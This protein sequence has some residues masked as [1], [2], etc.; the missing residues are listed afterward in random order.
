MKLRKILFMLVLVL[1]LSIGLV[2]CGNKDKDDDNNQNQQQPE[3]FEPVAIETIATTYTNNQAVQAEGIVYGVTA[4]GFY[5]SDSAD[6][7]LF[8][9]IGDAFKKD[10]AVG[11]KVQVTGKFSYAKN[12]IQINAVSKYEKAGTGTA[13]VAKAESTIPAVNAL[14]NSDKRVFGKVVTLTGTLSLDATNMY[15]LTDL[16]GNRIFFDNNSD[17][18]VLAQ[19][20]NKRVTLNAVVYKYLSSDAVWTLSYVGGSSEIVESPLTFDVVKEKALEH[21]NAVVAKNVYGALELPSVHSVLANIT[22]SWAVE[23]NDYLTIVDNVATVVIDSVDHELVL[24]VTVS[25]GNQSETIDFAITLKGIVEQTVSEFYANKPMVD[26]SKVIVRGII[27][28]FARNQSLSTRSV[29]VKDP[30]TNETLPIDFAKTGDYILNESETFKSLQIGD[31]IVVTA[32][33]SFSGR[34]TVQCVSK[35]EKRSSGNAVSHDFEN[36]YVLDSKESYENLAANVYDYSGQLVKFANP[37]INYSTSGVP[38]DTNWVQLGYNEKIGAEGF[39]INGTARKFALLIAAVNENLGTDSWHKNYEVPFVNGPA[40]QFNLEI[41]AYCLYVSDSYVAFIVPDQSAFTVAP[42]DQIVMDLGDG[43]PTSVEMGNITLITE[44]KYATGAI[45]WT[46]SHPAVID[47]ATGVVSEV[48]ENTV[49]TLTATYVFEGETKEFVKEVTVLAS[50]SISVSEL[51]ASAED[52]YKYKVEGVVV[53]FT[54]DGNTH[55]YRKGVLLM[56]PETGDLVLVDGLGTLYGVVY[57]DYVDASGKEITIGTMITVTGNYGVDSPEIGSGP[58]QTGRIHLDVSTGGKVEAGEVVEFAFNDEK[59]IVID[60]DEAQGAAVSETVPFGKLIKFVGTVENPIYFGGSSNTAPINY[61]VFMNN[62][63]DNNGTKY[64]GK[65]FSFKADNNEANAGAAWYSK[66]LA[67]PEA[68]VCPN[69]TNAPRAVVGTVYG[70]ITHVTSTYYQMAI[71]N[72]ENWDVQP[73]VKYVQEAV[74]KGLP[75]STEVGD[76]KFQ[77]PKEMYLTGAITWESSHELINLTTGVIGN[78]TE[79]TEVTL[80]GSFTYAGETVTVDHIITVLAPAVEEPMTV[81]EL[82]ASSTDLVSVRVK[83]VVIGFSSDGNSKEER[84]GLIVM[85]NATGKTVLLN[86]IAGATYPT[87]T[88]INGSVIKVGDELIV[89]GDYYV[90]TDAIDSKAPY[91]TNRHNIQ[92]TKMSI[93]QSNV[94]INYHLEDAIVIDSHAAAEALFSDYEA[95]PYG[96]II[97]LVGTETNP[98]YI[99]GSGSKTPFNLKVYF[100]NAETNDGTKYN[101]KTLALKSDVNAAI[102]GSD[103]WYTDLFG[104]DGAFVAPKDGVLGYQ[105]TGTLY[106]VITHTTGSYYQANLVNYAECSVTKIA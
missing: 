6:G 30:V 88:D 11:D 8:V 32:E 79:N 76:I 53:G 70:V 101:G 95:I 93:V 44:H 91:Q 60:S 75:T 54:S 51:L 92:V 97:K 67:L 57:P 18:E 29:I 45:T 10:V 74:V 37:F 17:I 62:A 72:I 94:A 12:L 87:Y 19:Y 36:A 5:L 83:G 89:E 90:S 2:S 4:N 9:V 25:D 77:L 103:T 14:S 49:V 42:A 65:T 13:A 61:K 84:K 26:D 86:N 21:L 73:E 59:A 41:Y 34:P 98:I 80:T 105:Y 38:A 66:Y 96:K 64:N 52:G 50:H 27:V 28:S 58:A 33:Y 99:G 63:V 43:I 78:V 104:I 16:E 23:A 20:A 35:V 68:F 81:T 40:Q 48:S 1:T 85:D 47:P 69:S 71:V 24:K 106:L 39:K 15:A 22:Y 7:H 56:D 3:V 100:S 55:E 31:E 102:T 46:S 82:V